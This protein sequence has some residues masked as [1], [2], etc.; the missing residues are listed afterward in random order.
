[1]AK[2]DLIGTNT[3]NLRTLLGNGKQYQVPPYQR[4][5]SWTEENWEDLWLDIEDLEN[6]E[7]QHYMG[8]LVLEE[9][10]ADQFKIIDGQQRLA[11]L[12]LLIIAAL[13]CLREIIA[14]GTDAKD[15]EERL[16]LL[17]SS[18]L[19]AKDPETL[20]TSPKL[21]LNEAN[22]RFFEG[23]LL[24]LREPASVSALPPHERPLWDA[25][26]FFRNKLRERFVKV[27]DGAGLAR[28]I[29]QT[30]ATKLL[31]INVIVE[32]ETGAYT[33]FETLNARGLELTAGD[34]LKNYLL[35]LVHPTGD[36][37]LRSAQQQWQIISGRVQP[38]YIAEFLRHY[39]NS[40]Q[41]LVRQE[42]VYKTIRKQV[43][44]PADVFTLLNELEEVSLLNEALN[45]PNHSL[46]DEVPDAANPVRDLKMYRV[47][48][49]RPLVFAAWF[50]LDRAE[51]GKL[52]RYLAVISFRYN[53]IAQRNTNRLEEV[54]NKVANE[55]TA[56]KHTS[57]AAIKD[58]LQPVYVQDDEFREAF[59]KRRIAASGQRKALVREILCR[60]EN[61]MH[62]TDYD[63]E[64]TTATIEHILP[65]SPD[66]TWLAA[67]P[68]DL[69]ERFVD[70]LGNYLLLEGKLNRKD[71]GNKPLPE[72]AAAYQ[73]STYPTTKEWTE[74]DWAPAKIEAR[75]AQMARV[76]TAVWRL[77]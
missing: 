56:G 64:T 7:R 59:S 40:K 66:A 8:A 65:E 62:G 53:M 14:T 23:T 19:G 24:D 77:P 36:G 12:S 45:D 47:V 48:Q 69:H 35:S 4:D 13:H 1:M 76:A 2:R 41:D 70:R 43:S 10:K 61:Q 52:L 16:D 21:T 29:N 50:K 31:F 3:V 67:F 73:K 22:K 34:L 6:G 37:N 33:V 38:K 51:L 30:L 55:I 71:A 9:T 5:Y 68:H 42:R 15:N 44:A 75:Q 49:Y 46:W 26:V 27:K 20:K 72:K 25:L 60:L 54:Y 32:D 63:W 58:A 74:T 17:R 39:L 11:T 18:F 28:F 57:A